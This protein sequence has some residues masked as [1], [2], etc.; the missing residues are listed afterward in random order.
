MKNTLKKA[1]VVCEFKNV[2]DK[3]VINISKNEN[4][5]SNF[6]IKLIISELTKLNKNFI[7]VR[8]KKLISYRFK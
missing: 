2:N 6:Q 1:K 8:K 5:I 3:L 4:K 7:Y